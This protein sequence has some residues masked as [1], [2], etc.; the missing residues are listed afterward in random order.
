MAKLIKEGHSSKIS[1]NYTVRP[2][3]GSMAPSRPAERSTGFG[4]S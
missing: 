2:G 3:N 4:I 1:T